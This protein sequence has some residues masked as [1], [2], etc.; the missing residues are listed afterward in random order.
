MFGVTFQTACNW[1]DGVSAPSA[2]A[3]MQ[4]FD[5]WGDDLARPVGR[6]VTRSVTSPVRRAA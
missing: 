4:A 5:W 1:F 3:V 6:P 2:R